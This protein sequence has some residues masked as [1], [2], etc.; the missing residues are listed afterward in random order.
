MSFSNLSL[1]SSSQPGCLLARL[2]LERLC[3]AANPKLVLMLVVELERL[4]LLALAPVP[5]LFTGI[6]VYIL[7]RWTFNKLVLART[8]I[9]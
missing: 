5:P 4:M 9:Q 7:K 3:S 1:S 6:F 2:S 8:S